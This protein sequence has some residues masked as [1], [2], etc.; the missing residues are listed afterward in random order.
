[1]TDNATPSPAHAT[2]TP[3]YEV[4]IGLIF[5]STLT[6]TQEG[7][8]WRGRFVR[9]SD[10]VSTGWG[11]TR[12]IYNGIP[13]GT[14]YDIHLDDRQKRRPM[15]IRTRRKAVYS[16]IVDTI[17]QMAGIAI[18]TRLL[19][20]L[21]A[22]ERYVVGGS[23]VSDEGIHISRKKLFKD[24]EVV[25]FPWRQVSVV[26]QQGNCIIHGERGFSECLPYNENNNTH[27]IDYAIEMALQ[28]GLTRLS[29]MLQ[30]AAQ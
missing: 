22:G 14:T 21:R 11:G 4:K 8:R 30:P 9:F 13:T 19:E 23:M 29:D 10:I 6:I 25:F 2:Q 27:I 1:M 28:N 3:I 18:L 15:T 24:P 5:R 16:T 17:W 7:V 20:G 12:H 26:R